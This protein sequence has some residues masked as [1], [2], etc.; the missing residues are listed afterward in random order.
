MQEGHKGTED[1]GNIRRD[2]TNLQIVYI[3][4][5]FLFIIIAGAAVVQTRDNF[6]SLAVNACTYSIGIV[7]DFI[8]VI[9][10]NNGPR[11]KNIDRVKIAFLIPVATLGLGLIILFGS[12]DPDSGLVEDILSWS[13]RLLMISESFLG[14]YTE[15]S[16]NRPNDD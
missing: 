12:Y 10:T 8:V 11:T 13:I 9:L 15:L 2:Y 4:K 14:P 5:L 1:I 6:H 7:F 3:A 16:L